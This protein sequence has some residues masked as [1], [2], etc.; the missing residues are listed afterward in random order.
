MSASE[1]GAVGTADRTEWRETVG[2]APCAIRARERFDKQGVVYV[3]YVERAGPQAG[4]RSWRP[5]TPR[6]T[7]RNERGELVPSRINVVMKHLKQLQRHLIADHE[8][9]GSAELA[10][11][12]TLHAL[13]IEEG[14]NRWLAS[15]P[16]RGPRGYR[17]YPAHGT[18]VCA[19]LGPRTPWHS[20][21]PASL[22]TLC[23]GMWGAWVP[24]VSGHTSR[25]KGGPS[26]MR[27]T[28]AVFRRCELWLVENEIL[29][30]SRVFTTKWKDRFRQRL[31]DLAAGNPEGVRAKALDTSRFGERAVSSPRHSTV[32]IG[33]VVLTFAH[34]DAD[35]RMTFALRLGMECRL[36]PVSRTMRS[37]LHLEANE[38]APHGFL[39]VAGKGKKRGGFITFT[40]EERALVDDTLTAGYLRELERAF[41]DGSLEDYPL[42][43]GLGWT[44]VGHAATRVV[45]HAPNRALRPLTEHTLG[46]LFA[47]YERL[48][49]V[50]KRSSR[51][52]YGL[53]RGAAD[54]ANG[55]PTDA[56]VR[57]YIGFWTSPESTRTRVYLD[58]Q[59]AELKLAVRASELRQQI[60][61]AVLAALPAVPA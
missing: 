42:F 1:N 21:T 43:P 4:R 6:L 31:S 16:A 39:R 29:A 61:A 49:G 60:R 13:T 34:P 53:R 15:L 22:N 52:W 24:P 55:I 17:E 25:P 38:H 54:V 7:L 36:G 45:R 44:R 27:R 41:K 40:L 14:F 35:P 19:L 50:R 56:V 20:L 9:P 11:S 37:D 46:I 32:E 59:V 2:A 47:D 33:R 58:S 57:D 8:R 5:L 26:Q 18:R 10:A 30:H 23:D 48:A 28:A 51:G 3:R 12:R